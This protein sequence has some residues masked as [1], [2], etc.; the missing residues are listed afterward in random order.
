MSFVINDF[1][2]S[3]SVIRELVNYISDF[4]FEKRLVRISALGPTAITEVF[5]FV[6]IVSHWAA[7][8]N[9]PSFMSEEY[10][11]PSVNTVLS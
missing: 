11:R 10:D 7:C 6:P 3:G 4:V 8:L 5:I 2:S 1:E 9:C